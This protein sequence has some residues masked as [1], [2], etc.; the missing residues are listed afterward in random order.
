MSGN[1]NRPKMQTP[2]LSGSEG[3]YLPFANCRMPYKWGSSI[4][5]TITTEP[6]SISVQGKIPSGVLFRLHEA[7]FNKGD[8]ISMRGNLREGKIE[9]GL[10]F[11]NEHGWVCV[12]TLEVGELDSTVIVPV[13]GNFLPLF[14]CDKNLGIDATITDIS[15]P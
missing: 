4:K 3:N 2:P 12:N 5:P 10:A 14:M 15:L 1:K 6:P 11:A 13:D 7:H 9:F 8:R